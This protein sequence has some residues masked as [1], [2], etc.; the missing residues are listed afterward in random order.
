MDSLILIGLGIFI[1]VLGLL[2]TVRVKSSNQLEVKNTEIILALVPVVFFLLFTGRIDSLEIGE[3]K[4]E[5]AFM[6]AS[7]TPIAAQISEV[8]GLPVT[9]VRAN[10]KGGSR[11][12]PKLINSKAEALQF[13]MGHGGYWGPTIQE[14]LVEL[15]AH[16]F[17]RFVVINHKDG[18]LWGIL[19]SRDLLDTL[20][21]G[22]GLT[23][24]Q[25]AGWLNSAT[26]E[27]P[28]ALGTVIP[29]SAA[30]TDGSDKRA[31][32]Q[33]MEDMNLEFLPV[34]NKKKRFVGIVDRSRLTASLIID[35]AQVMQ[36]K[37]K[38]S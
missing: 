6:E 32:L 30:L 20:E 4:I 14:Y 16:P 21:R 35:V 18:S 33:R 25:F 9:P 37:K 1:G 8:R 11:K 15:S 28:S 3:L 13:R 26:S 7:Q 23:Y 12:I 10:R 24:D 38:E 19:P 31:A 29:V 36:P 2:V 22:A 27:A 34:I 17:L 5:S